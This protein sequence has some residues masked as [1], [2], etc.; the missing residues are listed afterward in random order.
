M[1]AAA[2]VGDLPAGGDCAVAALAAAV[3]AGTAAGLAAAGGGVALLPEFE[4]AGAAFA[5]VCAVLLDAAELSAGGREDAR[6]RACFPL[7]R[8][9]CFGEASGCCTVGF[10]RL[11][12][13]SSLAVLPSEDG[14]EPLDV[15]SGC[16]VLLAD[17]AADDLVDVADAVCRDGDGTLGCELACD[18]Q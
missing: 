6:A 15:G 16:D 3:A 12:G 2:A 5:L 7:G 1:A 17:G 8:E 13:G 10:E 18:C 11:E 9:R 14:G 4:V